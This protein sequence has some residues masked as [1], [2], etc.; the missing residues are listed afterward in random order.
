MILFKQNSIKRTKMWKKQQLDDE[1]GKK[2]Q[3]PNSKQCTMDQN[4]ETKRN[5]TDHFRYICVLYA[6]DTRDCARARAHIHTNSSVAVYSQ[7][8]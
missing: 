8:I 3:Q 1:I 7:N 6:I 5:E 2:T 4:N